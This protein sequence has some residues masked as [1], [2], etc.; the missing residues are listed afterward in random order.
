MVNVHHCVALQLA[1]G[2]LFFSTGLVS[3]LL[4]SYLL[5]TLGMRLERNR[6]RQRTLAPEPRAATTTD[7]EMIPEDI[8]TVIAAAVA[9]SFDSPVRVRSVTR[10]E[11]QTATPYNL[12]S[13][14]GRRQ[15]YRSHQLR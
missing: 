11:T 5:V 2:P 6:N 15:I 12:W 14:E 13:I 4:L 9:A 1:D 3:G 10:A 8:L 7:P